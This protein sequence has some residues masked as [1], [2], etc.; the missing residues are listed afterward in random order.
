VVEPLTS[1]LKISA[2]TL[3][4]FAQK[5]LIELEYASELPGALAIISLSRN[6]VALSDE[7]GLIH[8]LHPGARMLTGT[9]N[10]HKRFIQGIGG[11]T[12]WEHLRLLMLNQD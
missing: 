11:R 3:E 8:I 4:E 7:A 9:P 10:I 5:G 2:S 12:R 1:I 6:A